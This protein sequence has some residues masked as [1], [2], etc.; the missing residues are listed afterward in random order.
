MTILLE[1]QLLLVKNFKTHWRCKRQ[2]AFEVFMVLVMVVFALNIRRD[3]N[4]DLQFGRK[5]DVIN[6]KSN[7]DLNSLS[8]IKYCKSILNL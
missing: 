6:Y 8:H 3:S 1:F 2:I 4:K 7:L 5:N